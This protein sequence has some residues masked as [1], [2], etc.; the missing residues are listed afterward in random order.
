ME[1]VLGRY[2]RELLPMGSFGDN[3]KNCVCYADDG[4][5]FYEFSMQAGM[6]S[7]EMCEGV[8]CMPL[9]FGQGV[10]QYNNKV[11]EEKESLIPL[12]TGS[13]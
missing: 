11:V 10:L 3:F 13:T 2:F 6:S 7:P 12:L 1:R 4:E 8:V 5:M 9:K